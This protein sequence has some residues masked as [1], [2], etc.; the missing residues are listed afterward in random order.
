MPRYGTYFKWIGLITGLS[1]EEVDKP[2]TVIDKRAYP[3]QCESALPSVSEAAENPIT[4]R[5]II[6]TPKIITE[7]N[8]SK[9]V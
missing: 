6:S 9:P 8:L 1:T 2:S 7:D 5:L 4:S 3:I